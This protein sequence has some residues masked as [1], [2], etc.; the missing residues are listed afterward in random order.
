MI[1]E[2]EIISTLGTYPGINFQ[3]RQVTGLI[4]H[5]L[6]YVEFER[7]LKN[8]GGQKKLLSKVHITVMKL[9]PV[10]NNSGR[11]FEFDLG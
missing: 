10:T 7:M 1:S 11:Y 8:G 6:H 9:N 2:V 5:I 4:N 3:Y